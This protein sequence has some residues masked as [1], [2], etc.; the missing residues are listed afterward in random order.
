VLHAEAL[1]GNPC[2]NDWFF[3]SRRWLLPLKSKRVS[4]LQ[5]AIEMLAC[6]GRNLQA[7]VTDVKFAIDR[8]FVR[9][10]SKCLF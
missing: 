9:V 10:R 7:M 3:H 2:D 1:D 4:P 6:L 8:Y 5:G